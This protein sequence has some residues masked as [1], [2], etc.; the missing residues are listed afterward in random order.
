MDS[1]TEKVENYENI[2]E[3]ASTT[4]KMMVVETSETTCDKNGDDT[5]DLL[6]FFNSLLQGDSKSYYID[7]EFESKALKKNKDAENSIK[8]VNAECQKRDID[9][10]LESRRGI[11][12]FLLAILLVQMVFVNLIIAWL[13]VSQTLNRSFL[14][15]LS[16]EQLSELVTLTKWYATATV[17]ELISIYIY[18]IRVLYK[19]P[20]IK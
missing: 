5:E 20:E 16:N 9:L 17:V 15:V 18:I 10:K 4:D 3:E 6:R 13:I 1:N 2:V 7:E 8:D 19:K 11:T 12:N 14:Y